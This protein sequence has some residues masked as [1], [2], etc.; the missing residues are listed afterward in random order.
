[1]SEAIDAIIDANGKIIIKFNGFVGDSCYG[2]GKEILAELKALGVEIEIEEIIPVESPIPVV[3]EVR[4][5]V[6]M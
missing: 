5:K 2:T 1:M 3:E 4:K 6:R